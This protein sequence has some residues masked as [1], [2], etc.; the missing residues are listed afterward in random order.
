MKKICKYIIPLLLL[1]LVH[2]SAV[3]AAGDIDPDRDVKLTISYQD[4]N[5]P[6]AGAEFRIYLVAT[7]DENG[8]LAVTDTFNQFHVDI[9]GDNDAAWKD[10][11]STLEGYVLRDN[12]APEDSGK[13]DENGY[14]VFPEDGKKLTQG[15]YLV[16][17]QRHTQG[18]Y[19]Y[20]ASPFMV[21]LPLQNVSQN[22]WSYEVDV[23]PK[24]DSTKIPDTPAAIT[25]KVLK[26]WDDGGRK[27]SRPAEVT[28]QLLRDGK[29]YDT[30]KLNAD[31][32]WRYKWSDLDDSYTWK[33]VEK[34]CKGYTARVERDGITFVIT[35]TAASGGSKSLGSSDSS[36]SSGTSEPSGVTTSTESRLPQTGQLWWPVPMLLMMGLLFIVIG[37]IRR[38]R[39]EDET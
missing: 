39:M 38:R 16:L 4:G 9:R 15:L 12:I 28:V 21:M 29:V 14:L 25:R 17:G 6:L 19:R 22:E 32:N 11:A 24:Y 5:T 2:S 13:T 1:L 33:V 34:E 18:K 8:K 20:D 10:L 3:C 36:D 37:L 27:Q 7:L 35:N 30:V 31:N 26:V 23:S